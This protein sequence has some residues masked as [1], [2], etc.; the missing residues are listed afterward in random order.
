MEFVFFGTSWDKIKG[1]MGFTYSFFFL[2]FLLV[3]FTRCCMVIL[4]LI[5]GLEWRESM[6]KRWEIALFLDTMKN[7]TEDEREIYSMCMC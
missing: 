7:R 3:M 5:G 4:F 2:L 1:F 6:T